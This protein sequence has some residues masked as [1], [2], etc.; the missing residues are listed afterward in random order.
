M[1]Y[2]REATKP[3]L[4]A[5]KLP[6]VLYYIYGKQ[7]MRSKPAKLKQTTN[8]KKAGKAFGKT[9]AL[10]AAILQAMDAV[11]PFREKREPYNTFFKALVGWTNAEK[12][13]PQQPMKDSSWFKDVRFVK[14]CGVETRFKADYEISYTN[15][16]E[17][18]VHIPAFVPNDSITAPPGC[19]SIEVLMMAVSCK[20]KTGEVLG[21]D[22]A[23]LPIAYNKNTHAA[24]DTRLNVPMPA[25]SLT[26]VAFALK[27]DN[28]VWNAATRK[29]DRRWM[30]AGI[31]GS[32]WR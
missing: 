25:D 2:L 28:I 27:Y 24:T 23:T 7:V 3:M 12:S 26:L 19:N 4:M 16:N 9:S 8:T 20:P 5:K 11:V 17:V 31:V 13:N 10:A 1:L 18:A 30:P 22:F 21:Q 14:E 6:V 15:N 29:A 32:W